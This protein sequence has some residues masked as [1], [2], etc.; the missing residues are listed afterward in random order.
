MEKIAETP[1]SP[2][3]RQLRQDALFGCCFCGNPI[4]QYHHIV[5]SSLLKHHNPED[6]M[7]ACPLCH[8]K[9]TAGAV[10]ESEQREAK[11]RPYNLLHGF[12]EGQLII[13]S[14]QLVVDLGGNWFFGS[15]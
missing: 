1:P 12:A 2:V 10:A 3:R 14:K 5:P 15:G 13:N 9:V 4:I 7:C 8:D 6:M 11:A